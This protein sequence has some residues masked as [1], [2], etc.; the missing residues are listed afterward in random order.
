MLLTC[1]QIGAEAFTIFVSN[2]N[3]HIFSHLLLQFYGSRIFIDNIRDMSVSW[4][5]TASSDLT[6]NSDPNTWELE[7]L[8]AC[9]PLR[10]VN[11]ELFYCD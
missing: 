8:F 4:M 2:N 9:S 3:I 6:G 7:E 1:K 10:T 5:Y 11:V